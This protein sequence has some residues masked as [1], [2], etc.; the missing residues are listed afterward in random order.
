MKKRS[1]VIL[2][3][4]LVLVFSMVFAGCSPASQPDSSSKPDTSKEVSGKEDVTQQ[5]VTLRFSWWGADT[6]HQATLAAMELYSQ[7]NPNVKIEGEYGAFSTFYQKLL[8]QL[9]GRTAPDIISVDYKWTHDLMKQGSPFVN[10]YTL[11]D[12]IDMNG[13]DLDFAKIYGG[14]DDYPIGL[15]AGV[16][17]MGYLYNVEFL[18]EFGIEPNNEWDWETVIENGKKVQAADPSKHLMYNIS[19]HWVYLLKTML[20]QINGNTI[21]NDDYSLGFSRDDIIQVFDY[22]RRLV[23]TG[24]VPPFEEGVLYENVYA[25]Q[26]PNW[27]NQNFGIFPTSS[28]LIPGIAAA[29]DFELDVFRYPVPKDAVDPGI[30]VTPSM[31]ITIY[32]HSKYQDVAADF[33]DFFFNDEEAIMILKDTRGVPANEKAKEMLVREGIVP[34]QVSDMVSQS[35][36]GAGIA[37]NGPSLN[38]EVIALIKDY[39]QQVGYLK[40]TPE[41]A[42]D[43]FMKELEALAASLK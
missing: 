35:L 42:A 21:L 2:G 28:S 31:F 33:I 36:T 17:G 38:P 39:I 27:L 40:L 24:T 37:E 13:F 29:S 3:F 32:E 25:D 23:E 26:N 9:A 12:K 4:L 14:D 22:I 19:E 16:N 30:L 41:Q 34:K 11:T 1:R 18:K 10:M 7:R 15:P 43:E 6:R 5:T 8:T 20:K